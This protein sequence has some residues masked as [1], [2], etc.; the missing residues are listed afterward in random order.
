M[1]DPKQTVDAAQADRDADA[2][3]DAA[4]ASLKSLPEPVA[5]DDA[6]LARIYADAGEVSAARDAAQRVS[7]PSNP[8]KRIALSDRIATHW[9][10]ILGFTAAA[11]A[12]LV[13][14]YADPTGL[15]AT[16]LG[17][18]AAADTFAFAEAFGVATGL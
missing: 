18:P 8:P 5:P 16:V 17:A 15:A 6:L 3:L 12:G 2:L 7:K 11:A 10:A 13:I 1:S 4:F 14:G 9:Q